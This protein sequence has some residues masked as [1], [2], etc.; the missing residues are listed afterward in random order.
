MIMMIRRIAVSAAAM[1]LAE[2][3]STS[4]RKDNGSNIG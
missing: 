4:R 3:Y 1:D 2:R